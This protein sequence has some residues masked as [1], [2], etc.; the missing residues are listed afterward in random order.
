[1]HQYRNKI[2]DIISKK[3]LVLQNNFDQ[4]LMFNCAL[5]NHFVQEVNEIWYPGRGIIITLVGYE[6]LFT[7]CK[8][9]GMKSNRI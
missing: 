2:C 9:G 7:S 3:D 1:M 5:F 8:N 4:M 6:I